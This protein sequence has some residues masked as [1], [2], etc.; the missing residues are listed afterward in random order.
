MDV[1]LSAEQEQL[2][3][4]LRACLRE[5]APLRPYVRAGY[6]SPWQPDEVWRALADMGILGLLVPEREGG[7]G[8]PLTTMG[9]AL[10]ELGRGLCPAPVLPSAVGAALALRGSSDEVAA[11]LRSDLATGTRVVALV[12]DHSRPWTGDGGLSGVVEWVAGGGD[13]DVLVVPVRGTEGVEVH[14]V[15]ADAPGVSITVQ[16]Q[17]DGTRRFARI[18]L[19]GVEG[20]AVDAGPEVADRMSAAIDALMVAYVADGL[21][22]AEA[23]LDLGVGY[24]KERRQFGAAIGTFQAVQH[25]CADM[26]RDVETT[27]AVTYYALWAAE[28]ADPAEAHR[29]ATMAKA[30][31]ADALPRVGEACIQVH[32]GLGF[33]WEHDAHLFHKRLLGVQ[34]LFGSGDDHLDELADLVMPSPD[35]TAR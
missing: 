30:V 32:G 9:I 10:E 29:A 15:D 27:R 2:R 25:L 14:V 8:A 23:A 34:A 21:G 11:D 17:I 5:R 13:A 22:A 35:V 24:A 19:D 3:D 18:E 16:D 31:A 12:V 28:G 1:E 6:G 20:Q 33:T 7:G 4:A 26:L